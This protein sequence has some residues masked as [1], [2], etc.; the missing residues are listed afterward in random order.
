M[1]NIIVAL[2]RLEDAKGVRNILVRNGFAV[3]GVCTTGA[4]AISQADELGSGIL[5]CGYKL[6]D[7]VYSELHECL[8]PEF[9]MLL[10]ASSRFLSQC[11]GSGIVCLSM[12]LKTGDLVSTVGMMA[13]GIQQRRR[14]ARQMPKV[15][16][17]EEETAIREAKAL[18]M[19]RNHMTEEEAHRY[20]QKCS[21][22]SSTNLAETA[23]M[24]LS[25][26]K[27]PA[28]KR[29]ASAMHGHQI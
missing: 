6:T 17:A 22:D 23:F 7:M 5:V 13:E 26:I 27:N 8:P 20:L 21:M 11:E 3:T 15:R 16:N 19:E 25:I 10:L 4:Q 29:P 9:E 18:L 24:I 28:A 12:P 1:T 2:P 14:R